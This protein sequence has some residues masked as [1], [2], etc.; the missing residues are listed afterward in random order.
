[1]N[2]LSRELLFADRRRH[3]RSAAAHMKPNGTAI[4]RVIH[5]HWWLLEGD[6]EVTAETLTCAVFWDIVQRGVVIPYRR[7]GTISVRPIF[8]GQQIQEEGFLD[9]LTL[10]DW[11]DRSS[12]NVGKEL[13]LHAAQYS[14]RAQI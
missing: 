5:F 2:D 14:S 12:R 4:C 3:W 1:M 10:E 13:P 7:F 6:Q 8:K 9:F 11:T